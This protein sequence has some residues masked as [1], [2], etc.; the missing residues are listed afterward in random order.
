MTIDYE[1]IDRLVGADLT[2]IHDAVAVDEQI[3]A[4]CGV[5]KTFYMCFV[6]DESEDMVGVISQNRAFI[7]LI[8]QVIIGNFSARSRELKHLNLDIE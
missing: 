1:Y 7:R 5:S 6:E 3:S 2:A 8:G 4:C